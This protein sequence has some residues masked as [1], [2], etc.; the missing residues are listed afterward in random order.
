MIFSGM[1]ILGTR[2]IS[3]LV[4]RGLPVL[5]GSAIMVGDEAVAFIGDKRFGKSTMAATMVQRGHTLVTDDV[6]VLD[7]SE[8]SG[9]AVRP[10]PFGMKLWPDAIE[11]L[12]IGDE[13]TT[14][15]VKA[16]QTYT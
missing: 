3:V 9:W 14:P 16:H 4:R 10:G 12:G 8:P 1:P 7:R 13:R 5:H 15:C 11:S 6:V 2:A